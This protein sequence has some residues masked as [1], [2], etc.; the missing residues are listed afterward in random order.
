MGLDWNMFLIGVGVLG[1]SLVIASYSFLF[2]YT[3]AQFRWRSEQIGYF[4]TATGATRTF[5]LMVL[6]PLATKFFKPASLSPPSPA[7]D[8][9]PSTPTSPLSLSSSSSLDRERERDKQTTTL[10]LFDLSI[11]RVSLVLDL[12]G[13]VAMALSRSPSLFL[14]SA[15]GECLGA[16]FPAAI[17]SAALEIYR[18][19]GGRE[20]GKLFGALSV[21]QSVGSQIIGPSLFGS[22]Y[23]TTVSTFPQAMFIVCAAALALSILITLPIRIRPAPPEDFGQGEESESSD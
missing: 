1:P 10:L 14:L 11:A 4:L 18:R 15:M 3:G 19:S 16:G 9:A 6:L 2:E 17:Q 5:H 23:T 13:F 20:T 22:I 21:M 7:A 8:E 12:L